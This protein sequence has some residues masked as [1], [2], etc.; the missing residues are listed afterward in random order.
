MHRF[1]AYKREQ[2]TNLI[3]ATSLSSKDSASK[4]P[5]LLLAFYCTLTAV[6]K[7]IGFFDVFVCAFYHSCLLTT[8]WSL[9]IAVHVLV[10]VLHNQSGSG[11]RHGK[12][13]WK[14]SCTGPISNVSSVWKKHGNLLSPRV[15][16]PLWFPCARCWFKPFY[17]GM[18]WMLSCDMTSG[19]PR[20]LQYDPPDIFQVIWKLKGSCGMM[21]G[22]QKITALSWGWMDS[23]L[24]ILGFA[25]YDINK[26][27]C[28]VHR[29]QLN[30]LLVG[31][32]RN[33][34]QKGAGGA[35]THCGVNSQPKHPN[36]VIWRCFQL[37]IQTLVWFHCRKAIKM[38]PQLCPNCFLGQV[39][40]DTKKQNKT[41]KAVSANH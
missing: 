25:L 41:N 31:I 24:L 5:D 9:R 26:L 32:T 4:L 16:I 34:F 3:T 23:Y 22:P 12:T 36:N 8:A 2:I 17:G 19:L 37:L 35:G 18:S 6:K 15:W 13:T 20:K 29:Q 11:R 40:I 21:S 1:T 30:L 7:S 33:S 39:R 10:W 28:H 14:K 38:D 27:A